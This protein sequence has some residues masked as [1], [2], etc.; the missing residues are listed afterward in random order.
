MPVLSYHPERLGHARAAIAGTVEWLRRIH[1]VDPE[2]AAALAFVRTASNELSHLW[3]PAVAR[4]LDARPLDRRGAGGDARLVFAL[5]TAP[6]GWLV[7]GDAIDMP[8]SVSAEEVAEWLNDQR[9]LRLI[10][11]PE[12][13][14]WM[15]AVM[16]QIAADP[17]ERRAFVERFDNWPELYTHLENLYVDGIL[18]K[19]VVN[20]HLNRATI[21]LAERFGGL[22]D[23]D[24]AVVGAQLN[25]D[26]AIMFVTSLRL[27]PEVFGGLANLVLEQAADSGSRLSERSVNSLYSALAEQPG[28]LQA[29]VASATAN[30]TLLTNA[31]PDLG[32]HTATERDLLNRA[33]LDAELER[34]RVI[35]TQRDLTRDEQQLLDS[36][37]A[38]R[39]ELQ[40]FD[41]AIDPLSGAPVGGQ[42]YIFEPRAF[43]GDGRVAIALGNLDAADHIAVM[44]PGL[45]STVAAMSGE[46]AQN[47]YDEARSASDSG[48]SVA[49]LHWMGYDSPPMEFSIDLLDVA[50]RDLA[51]AGADLLA[52]D[53][54]ALRDQ[55]PDAHVTVIG[56]SYGSTTVAIAAD[57]EALEADDVVLVGSP[58][59]GYADN[60]RDLSTGNEHT[61]VGAHAH[62]PVTYL[63]DNDL[64]LRTVVTH[65]DDLIRY[66]MPI[67]PIVG[68]WI[69]K[70]ETLGAD[71]AEDRFAARRFEAQ[72]PLGSSPHSSYYD[73]Q[74][75]SLYNMSAIVV[76]EYDEVDL[77][78]HR[79]DIPLLPN[80]DP[81]ALRPSSR[82]SHQD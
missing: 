56:H 13:L 68:P 58:G 38:V 14:T 27:T 53:I 48:D 9:R 73:E 41:A 75:E 72:A 25:G 62:D 49:V 35:G 29:Y 16:A 15:D 69:P 1:R 45:G 61:W 79:T 24:P 31:R 12:E 21:G 40:H 52:D 59:A 2:A 82:R 3:A 63:S 43:D 11:T 55:R 32:R 51:E 23:G 39:N 50:N 28:A 42:L 17:S 37:S 60:A 30:G 67:G 46:S 5:D 66:A 4:V 7:T 54:E 34:L 36:L 47:V 65:L 19:R 80:V 57:L 18:W 8:M 10:D 74:S 64:D 78:P 70:I 22:F 71:P 20:F 76:G 6:D 77:A 44:V 81:E 33:Y 26:A